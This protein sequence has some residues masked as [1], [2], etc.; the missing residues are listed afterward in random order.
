MKKTEHNKIHLSAKHRKMLKNLFQKYL[1]GVEVWAYGSRVN[2]QS[3]EGSDLDLVL[4]GPDLK[5][6]DFSQFLDMKDALT[7]SNIP[8][9]V[10]VRD[11]ARLPKNFHK[12]IKKSYY[13][14][15]KHTKPTIPGES[16]MPLKVQANFQEA[17]IQTGSS[18]RASSPVQTGIQPSQKSSSHSKLKYSISKEGKNKESKTKKIRIDQDLNRTKY[19]ILEINSSKVKQI[20]IEK[21]LKKSQLDNSKWPMVELGNICEIVRGGSPRPIQR[22]ITSDKNGIN[23]IKI[24]DVSENSKYITKTKQKIKIEGITKTRLVKN[25]DFII[26]NSMSFGRPYI[27][28]IDGAI[29]DGWLLVRINNKK[30][31]LPDFLYQAIRSCAVQEQYQKLAQGSVVSNLNC[32]LVKNVQIY[33]PSLEEQKKIAGVLIQIQKAI[34]VQDKFIEVTTELKKSTMKHLFNYGTKEEKTTQTEIGLIPQD[35]KVSSIYNS[36]VFSKKPKNL[37]LNAFETVSF[38]PME[39]IPDSKVTLSSYIEKKPDEISSGVYFESGDLLLSKITPSFENGKQCITK[40]IKNKFGIATTEV[41]PI[42][43]IEGTSDILFLF[44]YLLLDDIRS[45]IKNK[46]EG[47]TGRKRVPI[48]I[49]KDLKIPLP[50]IEE[51]RQIAGVLQSIDKKIEAHQNEKTVL[52]ELFKTT[53]QKLMTAQVRVHNLNIKERSLHDSY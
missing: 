11:W 51:Q 5:E 43:E 4:R 46:M 17:G 39:L 6:I 44:Y 34:E 16:V 52:N 10:E 35:W 40:D 50:P 32:N 36:Y 33:L 9:L 41:I 14:L 20:R 1:P 2:G 48:H 7:E 31:I 38:V 18:R 19:K 26:S 47:S 22:Y 23:W 27:L 53:L 15:I 21:N 13:V 42:K 28:K 12:E 3:H 49:I 30:E 29:H 45:Q 24:G 8:F 25:G 37:Q